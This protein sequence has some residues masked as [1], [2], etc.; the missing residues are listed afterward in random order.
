[1]HGLFLIC[2]IFFH[3]V[4]VNM[5][6][7]ICVGMAGNVL[8]NEQK[9]RLNN[10][11]VE[12]CQLDKEISLPGI[13]GQKDQQNLDVNITTAQLMPVTETTNQSVLPGLVFRIQIAASRVPLSVRELQKIYPGKYPVEMIIEDEWYKYQ[14]IG[15]RLFSDALQIIKNITIKGVY[16]VAYENGNK[17]NLAVAVRKNKALERTIKEKGRKAL[18]NEIEYHV[19]LAASRKAMF[20]DEIERLYNGP[21]P[22][23]LILEDGWYKYHLKGGNSKETA[24]NLKQGCGIKDAFIVCY[25]GAEKILTNNQKN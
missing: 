9:A 16:I 20:Q 12:T 5:Q 13:P 19:Q 21:E 15:E 6:E 17:T 24:E 8:N 3:L 23:Y 4:S 1:M 22:V 11:N 2:T 7:D 25:I 10:F 14:L 18:L